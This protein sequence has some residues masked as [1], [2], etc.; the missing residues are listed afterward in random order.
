MISTLQS[1]YDISNYPSIVI[2]NDK[3]EGL[4]NKDD[5]LKIICP[6][7]STKVEDCADLK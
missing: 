2:G 3:Y 4:T 1:T 5:I 6:H 7:Y